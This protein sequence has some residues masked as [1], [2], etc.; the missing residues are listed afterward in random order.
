[1]LFRSTGGNLA[2]FNLTPTDIVNA[3]SEE[4]AQISA[5]AFGS[6]PTVDGQQLNATITAQSLL[7]TPEDFEQVVIRAETNGGL[8]LLNDVARVEIG[9]ENYATISRYNRSNSTGMAISLAP[10][11]NALDAA[12]AVKARLDELSGFFP[13]GVT[14]VIPYDTTPF[15]LISIEEVVKDRKSTRLNSSHPV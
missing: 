9:A 6:R 4:N 13:D 11:A 14:Y 1:M 15:V 10:G 5:G 2:A 12:N 3:V 8:V 7:R